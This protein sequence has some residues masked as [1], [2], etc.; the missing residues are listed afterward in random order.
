MQYTVLMRP[1]FIPVRANL[2]PARAG[3]KKSQRGIPA[4]AQASDLCPKPQAAIR[5]V[6]GNCRMAAKV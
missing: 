1:F 6:A 4:L 2:Q 5:L 3:K